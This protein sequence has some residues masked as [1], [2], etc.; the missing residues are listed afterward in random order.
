MNSKSNG[1]SKK[2]VEKIKKEEEEKVLELNLENKEELDEKEF[3]KA[4]QK[5]EERIK[6]P[7]D[8]KKEIYIKILKELIIPVVMIVL[9]AMTYILK[10]TLNYVLINICIAV[11]GI[12]SIGIYEVSYRKSNEEYFVKG[13]ELNVLTYVYIIFSNTLIQARL[14]LKNML[15]YALVI[16]VYYV[17]KSVIIYRIEKKKYIKN[18]IDTKEIVKD[19]RKK[20]IV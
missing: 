7:F 14:N 19:S 11:L 6:L 15:I 10:D 13:L 18:F 12:L 9:F 4:K 17:I 5:Y 2:K 3:E 1:K 8:I 20:Y 16:F